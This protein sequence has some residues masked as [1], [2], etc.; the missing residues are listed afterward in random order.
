MGTRDLSGHEPRGHQFVVAPPY[1]EMT[2]RPYERRHGAAA[3]QT[4]R[5]HPCPCCGY[6][7]LP[8]RGDYHLCP[9]CWWEDEG[10]GPWEYSGPNNETLYE[11]Q[12]AFLADGRVKSL[13][14]VYETNPPS[15]VSLGADGDLLG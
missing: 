13:G 7:T 15:G 10:T 4:V 8:S 6:K 14:V 2:R 3:L 9:V 11:A 5:V 12:Q 1:L